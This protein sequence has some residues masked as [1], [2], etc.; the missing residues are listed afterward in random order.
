M[1]RGYGGGGKVRAPGAAALKQVPDSVKRAVALLGVVPGDNLSERVKLID[2]TARIA[3][4][5]KTE[6]A[7]RRL[8]SQLSRMCGSR[9]PH[10]YQTVNDA[11]DYVRHYMR[12]RTSA[13]GRVQGATSGGN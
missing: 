5:V 7:R 8:H 4:L 3:D 13:N 6:S 12:A 1:S 9:L 2:P 10:T 11:I